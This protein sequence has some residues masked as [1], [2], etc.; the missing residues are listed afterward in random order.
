MMKEQS[1]S[2]ESEGSSSKM[3]T[4]VAELIDEAN[5]NEKESE[6]KNNDRSKFKKVEM[7]VFNGEDPDAWLFRADKYFQIQKLTDSEK[8]TVA[9]RQSVSKVQP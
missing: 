9:W 1:Q 5:S 4:K 3:K 6:E 8:M 2:R 7:L